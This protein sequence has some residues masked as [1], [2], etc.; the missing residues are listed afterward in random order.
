[1]EHQFGEALAN[2]DHAMALGEERSHH[3]IRADIL[4]R[5]KRF[6]EAIV[7]AEAVLEAEPDHWHSV[8][9]IM[10]CLVGLRRVTDAEAL[11]R[12]LV[13][14][15]PLEPR[16][17][18][19]AARFHASQGQLSR[20]VNY[21]DRVLG[22]DS[23]GQD[24]RLLRGSLLFEMGDYR[25]AV[26]DLRLHASSHPRSVRTHCR[27]ADSLFEI[28]EFQEAIEVAMHL[29][30]IDPAHH[31]AY[32]VRG[33]ALVELGHL[34]D[35]MAAFD[36]LL[37]GNHHPYLLTAASYA[38]RSGDYPAAEKYLDRVA[39]LAPDDR[40]LWLKRFRLHIDQGSLDEA[41]E[42][43]TRV[44]LLRGGSLLGRL[45]AAEAFAA[46][47]PLEVALETVEVCVEAKHFK[48]Q[49]RLHKEAIVAVLTMSV[50]KFGP[51][52]L[53]EGLVKL[54]SLLAS[55]LHEGVLGGILT[56]LL[57]DNMSSFAGSLDEW[58]SALSGLASSL[59]DL[60]DCQ[61]PIGMLRTAV[62]YTKTGDEKQLLTLPLE[63]RR[64]LQ[65]VLPLSRTVD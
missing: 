55:L 36:E 14:R 6:E 26:E 32:L 42:C 39:D 31:H 29:L 24:A 23:D 21:V 2:V 64:L 63:Q 52:H 65:E 49:E 59:A 47:R 11:A 16:A 38:H 25:R 17:L 5:L 58:E 12:D 19:A 15:A 10:R 30:E 7:D 34:R 27:L 48:S 8:E 18:L 20:A 1:M 41:V 37:R 56:D 53:P 44:E 13:K 43:A 35:A 33:C 60:P 50:R 51:R 57:R 46:T 22:I 45:L 61:I 54:R 40:E 4:L 28:G 3:C 62:T 9:Q